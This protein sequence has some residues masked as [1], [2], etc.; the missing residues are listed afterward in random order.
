MNYPIM[1]LNV[2]ISSLFN[3]V[4]HNFDTATFSYQVQGSHLMEKKENTKVIQNSSNLHGTK[5]GVQ[6]I[7][8]I[9]T[10]QFPVTLHCTT[11]FKASI[12]SVKD[13]DSTRSLECHRAIKFHSG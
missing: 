12:I 3:Q 10:V 13:T 4:F 7:N 2:D 9:S 6:T 11:L 1:I 8:N 5:L